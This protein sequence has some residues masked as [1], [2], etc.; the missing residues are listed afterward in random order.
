MP[1]KMAN[2]NNNKAETIDFYTY[3]VVDV[4][5]S[6]EE[7]FPLLLTPTQNIDSNVFNPKTDTVENC[8]YS[9][10]HSTLSYGNILMPRVLSMSRFLSRSVY[11]RNIQSGSYNPF[12]DKITRH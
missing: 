4:E 2:I 11:H 8:S 1:D 12:Y 9:R 6:R 3:K 10:H 5:V 7:H